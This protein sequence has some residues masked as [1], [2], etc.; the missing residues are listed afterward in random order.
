M[1]PPA[2]PRLHGPRLQ[3]A[4]SAV[5]LVVSA[6]LGGGQGGIGDR[7]AQ[8]LAL[9]LLGYLA[10]G[11]QREPLAWRG[12]SWARWLPLLVAV[13]PALQLLPIPDALWAG[14]SARAELAAQMA[15]AGVAHSAQISLNPQATEHA[16]WGLAPACALFLSAL[17]LSA[18][19]Q[20]KLMGIVVAI[21]LASVLLALLQLADGPDSLLR[22][23][24]PTN[25]GSG[26][27]LFANSNHQASLL[28]LCLPIVLAA[29]AWAV[30]ARIAGEPVSL[31]WPAAAILALVLL[32]LGIGVSR[33]R[34]G[35]LLGMVALLGS[36]PIVLSMR[37]QR[38]TTRV[39]AAVLGL[40]LVLTVQF[41][42]FG[43]LQR[44]D[45]DPLDDGRWHIAELTREAGRAY[46]PL[47]SG[48]GTFRHAYQPF[49]ARS[50]PESAIVNHAHDDYL[51]LWL[52]G[53]WP[54]L[55]AMAIGGL[56]WLSLGLRLWL[57][58]GPA[59][60]DGEQARRLLARTA[61]LSASLPLLHSALDYPLRTTTLMSV[62]ALLAAIAFTGWART[63]P[64]APFSRESLS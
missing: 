17:S 16:L 21:A 11:A 39:L 41:A 26:V 50:I 24:H 23:Y 35:L 56:A 61:W 29:A 3:F 14:P 59:Q 62:F 7:L 43:V 45:A 18:A 64:L 9:G 2:V 25:T 40:G 12:P 32:F 48:I 20:R 1:A 58:G 53:S 34:G 13:V 5:L 31:F 42:L 57:P 63:R 33:S 49:E 4:L 52:E 54:A 37:R 6:L 15:V 8:V 10:W 27:G 22:V 60:D 36:L 55:A 47:G 51:E 46:A 38:G 44:L 19:A 30:S 28:V